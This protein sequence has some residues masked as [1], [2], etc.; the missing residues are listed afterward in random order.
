MGGL[1]EYRPEFLLGH[2]SL[3]LALNRVIAQS[4]WLQGQFSLVHLEGWGEP[5]PS[6]TF[7]GTGAQVKQV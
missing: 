4:Q 2:S 6:L 1:A 7:G 3:L 5:I